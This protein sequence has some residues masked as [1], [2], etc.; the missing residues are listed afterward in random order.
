MSELSICLTFDDAAEEAAAFYTRVIDDSKITNTA[1]ADGEDG[2]RT[3]IMVEFEI[4]GRPMLALNT[5]PMF[6][7]TPAVSLVL[8][9]ADQAEIDRYWDALTA[10]GGEPG[11]C[12]WLTDKFGLSWQVIPERIGELMS[13]PRRSPDVL[14]AVQTMGKIEIDRLE[15]AYAGT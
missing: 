10:D 7:F 14:A 9:C 2:R 13:D 5:G 11:P 3:V 8:N 4:H 6:A 12:G 15:A 1:Y